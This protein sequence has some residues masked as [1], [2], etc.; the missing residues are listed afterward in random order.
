MNLRFGSVC[1]GIEAATVA[2]GPLG[3]QPAWLSEIEPWPS[4]LLAHHYPT[5][6]NLGDMRALPAAIRAGTVEAPD[7]LCGGTPCQAFSVAGLRNSLGDDRGNLTLT[8][9][10]IANAI[11]EQRTAAGLPECIA[12]WE[13]VPGVLSTKDNAFGCF[14]GQLAGDD[15]PMEPEARPAPGKSS[16]CWRWADGAHTP[17]WPVA[18][19]VVGP[20]RTVAW[21]VLDS[22]YFGVAQRRRRV[23]V[24]ASARKWFN[25]L[26]VLFEW[27]GLRRDT[28]PSR[29]TG[30]EIAATLDARTQGGGFPGTDGACGGHVVGT[31]TASHGPAGHGGSGLATNGGAEAGHLIPVASG[32]EYAYY[33]HDFA[34]DRLTATTGVNPA[35]T[36]SATASGNLNI[37]GPVAFGGNRTSGPIDVSPALNACASASG[38]IDFESEAFLVT[39][40]HHN[41]QAAQLPTEARDTGVS[42]SLTCSQ[43]AAV[44]YSTKLHNIASNQ[45]GKIYREYTVSLDANSP[46]PAL[47]TPWQVRRL[48]PTECERLQA[49]PDGYTDVPAKVVREVPPAGPCAKQQVTAT[50]VDKSGMF[51]VATNGCE[52]PQAVCPRGDLPSG[53]GY[54][55]CE[56]VCRQRGHAE[57]QAIKLAGKR[58]MGG[59]LFLQGHTG[60]CDHCS[61]TAQTAGVTQIIVGPPSGGSDDGPRYK[62]LGNSW[63]T[64]LVHWIGNR[65]E[66]ELK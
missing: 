49:F 41:A 64:K 40:F 15:Q 18:G 46:A 54:E 16:R 10:D 31:L 17:S 9:C 28:A 1:S 52:N 48:T 51:Y 4:K 59:T 22:Q 42:S 53:V 20:S 21:R 56:H 43:H 33:S 60:P 37:A 24:V 35:L 14:L 5:V 55:L 36:A 12:V 63:T 27:E 3:W 45:A 26:A 2:W 38:R 61:A 44:A 8:Y 6:P 58:A 65:I 57:V 19:A 34:H 62:A 66:N 29:E 13:N 39:A 32:V 11:D 47:L 23:F 50:L 7:V 25:P 30:E